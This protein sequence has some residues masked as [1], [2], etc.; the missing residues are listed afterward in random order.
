[1]WDGLE[2]RKFPRVRTSC[3]IE[4]RQGEANQTVASTTENLG[5]GGFCTVLKQPLVKMSRVRIKL[6]LGDGGG[7]V[8]CEGRVVWAVENRS[9][10]SAQRAHDTG[11]EFVGLSKTNEERI[12]R[13]IGQY[14]HGS[15]PSTHGLR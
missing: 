15:N 12:L 7:P 3:Q 1:M 13:I 11:I 2:S 5:K 6:D 4:I 9:F 10:Q 14:N 8:E